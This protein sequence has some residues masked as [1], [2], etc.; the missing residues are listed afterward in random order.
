MIQSWPNLSEKILSCG[1]KLFH[2]EKYVS[3]GCLKDHLTQRGMIGMPF[4][5]IHIHL[6]FF[7]IQLDAHKHMQN[8]EQMTD[9]EC[10]KVTRRTSSKLEKI[11]FLSCENWCVLLGEIL[12]WLTSVVP[13]ALMR[14]LKEATGDW[15][16]QLLSTR[17]NFFLLYT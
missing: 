8:C 16:L 2:E 3:E 12:N 15:D 7:K 5:E 11:P 4:S 14:Q 1:R 6:Q 10:R 9:L 13:S 17:L